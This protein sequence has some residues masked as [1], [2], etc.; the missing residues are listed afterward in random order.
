MRIC[1]EGEVCEMKHFRLI[2]PAGFVIA[3]LYMCLPLLGQERGIEEFKIYGGVE[4]VRGDGTV[5][6]LFSRLPDRDS[7]GI[8]EDGRIIG[9]VDLI[10]RPG[11]FNAKFN[12][13]RCLAYFTI[14]NSR[15]VVLLKA[16]SPVGISMPYEKG[17]RDFA[18][19][20]FPLPRRFK[21]AITGKKDGREMVFVPG[22][23]FVLGS[24]GR[25]K[26]EYPEQISETGDFYID[27]YEVSNRDY[28][29]YVREMKVP[30]PASWNG[31]ERDD[32]LP[33][34]VNYYEAES[35]ARWAG[36]RL[37]TEKEWEKA[38][39]G[40]GLVYVRKPDESYELI[41]KTLEYPWGGFDPS[42]SNTAAFWTNP[43]IR[44]DYTEKFP[45]GL[46][47]VNFF[48]GAGESPY[49]ALN[50]SGNAPE[51]TSSFYRAYPGNP[52]PAPKF[53]TMYKVVRGGGWFSS[54]ENA[55]ASSRQ[56][57][58]LPNLAKD[59]AGFRCVRDPLEEDLI[60]ES[61]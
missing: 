58:G 12:I 56:V 26:E 40:S 61:R 23:K 28:L 25:A 50:M 32:D 15:D 11:F 51:W 36:K 52:Y 17:K 54:P 29:K 18:D 43:G 19:K 30:F 49:G 34:L 44:K 35:Y 39:R 27:K 24:N 20:P 22:G 59:Y 53:G 45:R 21:T 57:G 38:A 42:K 46:L 5:S 9:K 13:Y 8:I 10:D 48:E 41:K 6:V 31:A 55:R 2:F 37:P 16:G 1:S 14:N 3:L 4:A 33:V 47:P 60:V 7:F